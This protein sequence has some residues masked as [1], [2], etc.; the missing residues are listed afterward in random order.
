LSCRVSKAWKK[1][2]EDNLL[3]KILCK[4]ECVD[5]Y[6][7]K[8]LE[9]RQQGN[10]VTTW[11][12]LFREITERGRLF[13]LYDVI[14]GV[15][16]QGQM[17]ALVAIDAGSY[18]ILNKVNFWHHGR[19]VI[20]SM[21]IARGIYVIPPQWE[22]MGITWKRSFNSFKTLLEKLF[23]NCTVVVDVHTEKFR[24][25]D[26]FSAKLS[27]SSKENGVDIQMTL[28]FSYTIGDADAENTLYSITVHAIGNF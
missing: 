9:T 16:T 25:D 8:E 28:D 23:G 27:T 7:W 12:V 18:F 26:C 17:K 6:R 3:W 4:E 15:T 24:G 14:L 11:K 2:T 13:P 5:P 10:D 20:W 19:N 21:Y 22:K 1:L